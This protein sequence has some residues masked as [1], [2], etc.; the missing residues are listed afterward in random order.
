MAI[1]YTQ[2]HPCLTKLQEDVLT[3]TGA[4]GA[5][6]DGNFTQ[7]VFVGDCSAAGVI[8]WNATSPIAGTVN[9][10]VWLQF[11]NEIG[12][13]HMAD[14]LGTGG[15]IGLTAATPGKSGL[16]R[17]NTY[18]AQRLYVEAL[19]FAAGATDVKAFVRGGT[20]NGSL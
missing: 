8:A 14:W 15:T 12:V 9:V 6:A 10:R 2:W 5:P 3:I 4:N 19:N 7:G 16:F 20:G 11:D 1:G 13:W 18:G 17:V